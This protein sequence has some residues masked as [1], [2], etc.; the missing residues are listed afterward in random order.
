[1]IK[2]IIK[3]NKN[4]LENKNI[5]ISVTGSIAIYKILELI[6][7]LTKTG[8][9][10]RVIMSKDA[11]KFITKL[12]FETLTSN[13]VLDE[14][15][16]SWSSD[17]NHIA[18]TKW[19]DIMVIAPATAHTINKLSNGLADNL[20]TQS[21]LAYPQKKLIAPSMNTNMLQNPITQASLKMLKLS[22][23]EIISPISKEL[24]CKDTGDGAM[25]NVEDIYYKIAKELLQDEY[26][27]H[28]KVVVTS[29]GTI[30]KIDD[31]RFISNYSSGKMGASLAMALYLRGANVCLISTKKFD[32]PSDLYT[33]DVT[34]TKEMYDY[35]VDSIRVA[36]KGTLI[37]PTLTN[38]LDTPQL[39]QKEPYLFMTS[40]VSDY[41][42]SFPQEGK[43]K[44][45]M[46]GDTWSLELKQNLDIISNIQKD[47]IKIVGFKAEM[48]KQN[49]KANAKKALDT[50]GLDVVCLNVLDDKNSFGS[51]NNTIE[52]ISR[53]KEILLPQSDKL[54]ISFDILKNIE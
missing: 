12:T 52:I 8:A 35:L 43:L 32:L 5:L 30:E 10:V 26:W 23:Y 22:N 21:A 36:K 9:N 1:L 3:Y 37:K 45:E 41:I 2:H 7:L 13:A 24:A 11:Q 20:V 6:R 18:I 38:G 15:S 17:M 53:Q 51:D 40:A 54:S 27:L 14:D 47:G 19:A 48:D 44:K 31:V 50:K 33:I 29:G 16:E 42:P 46:L 49:A 34:S 39:I 28:R 4:L 25:A